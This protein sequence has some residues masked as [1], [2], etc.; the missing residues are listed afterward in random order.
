MDHR[1]IPPSPED[2]AQ[3]LQPR[4]MDRTLRFVAEMPPHVCINET[5][6][7]PDYSF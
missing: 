7:S 5:I 1:P 3:M 2:R 4:D 6:I